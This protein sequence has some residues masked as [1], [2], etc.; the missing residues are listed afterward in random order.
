MCLIHTYVW[1]FLKEKFKKSVM[2]VVKLAVRR[3]RR[4]RR[5]EVKAWRNELTLSPSERSG[6]ASRFGTITAVR[7]R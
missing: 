6:L 5:D 1:V 7:R 3:R 4:S 2:V